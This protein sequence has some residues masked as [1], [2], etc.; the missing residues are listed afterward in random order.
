VVAEFSGLMFGANFI[1]STVREDKILPL[2]EK[3]HIF[4]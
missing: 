4:S 2:N 3:G 1:F